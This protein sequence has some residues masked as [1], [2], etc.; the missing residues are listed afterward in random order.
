[1]ALKAIKTSDFRA[2]MAE[3]LKNIND[4]PIILTVRDTSVAVMLS[5]QEY[6]KLIERLTN[7]ENALSEQSVDGAGGR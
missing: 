2:N 6:N 7:A 4:G 5:P 1:M 3:Y